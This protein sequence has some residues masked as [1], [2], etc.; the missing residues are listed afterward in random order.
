MRILFA[1]TPDFA[2]VIL[3]ALLQGSQSRAGWHVD[4]VYTQPDRP[5]G[6]GR[7]LAPGPVKRLA[8]AHG[9]PVHQPKTC[10]DAATWQQLAALRPD[11]LVVAAYGLLLPPEVLEIPR[12]GGIN[13][14]ASLLPR[15]RGAAPIQRAILAGDPETGISIM[16]M[17]KG[18]DTG[19]VLG[20][21]TCPIRADDTAGAL[22]DRLAA[23]GASELLIAL[24]RLAAGEIQPTPQDDSLATHAGRLHKAEGAL[25][26]NLSA[27]ELE[28]KVRAF[29][30]WPVAYT[31]FQGE[32][33]RVWRSAVVAGEAEGAAP[34]AVLARAPGGIDIATGQGVLRLLTVQ[35]PGARPVPV[36]DF[37]NGLR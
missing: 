36:A 28:R 4:A 22:H 19:P 3:E 7:R 31:P 27:V 11:V 13:V 9:V 18:L 29:V 24:D 26:W 25:D 20:R 17:E 12:H 15:W 8:S 2:A 6:R 14:H 23:L 21:A 33:L 32:N 35:R 16:Q 34:G 37:L 1:G 30:P 5:A 10:R